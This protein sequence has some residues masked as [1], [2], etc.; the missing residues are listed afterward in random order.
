MEQNFQNHKRFYAAHHFVFYPV[1]IALIVFALIHA[2]HEEQNRLLYIF[3]AAGFAMMGWLSFMLRQHYGMTLQNRLVVLEL[4]YRYFA[5]TGERLEDLE[6]NLKRS[7]LFALRFSPDSEL[8]ALVHRAVT[9]DLPATEIKK[10]I[11]N[12][13]GDHHRI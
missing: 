4:R 5:L 10:A 12:W 1:I 7:Q 8:K 2:S 13:K 9:E 11:V 6:A 3:I